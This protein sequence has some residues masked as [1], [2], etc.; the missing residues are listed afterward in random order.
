MAARRR[1][2][3]EDWT[4]PDAIVEPHPELACLYDE[5]FRFYR[6][7]LEAARGHWSGP[8]LTPA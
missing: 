6:D 3:L 2:D 5:G 7:R 4:R 8:T 1:F